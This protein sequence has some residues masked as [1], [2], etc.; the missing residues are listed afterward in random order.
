MSVTVTT[1]QPSY[2]SGSRPVLTLHI[3]NAGKVS[4]VRDVSHQLRSIEVLAVGNPKPVWMSSYCYA[5]NT[6]EIHT[7]KPGESLSY[8]IQWAGRTAAPGCPVQRTTLPAGKYEVIGRLGS[9]AGRP[10]PLTLT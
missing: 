4:C 5:L 3:A 10:T 8:T 7:F 1:G 9:L 2:P 6:H